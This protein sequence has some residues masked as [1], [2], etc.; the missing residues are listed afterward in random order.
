MPLEIKESRLEPDIT[1]L[2]LAGRLELGGDSQRLEELVAW[3]VGDGRLGVL[4]D[5]TQLEYI[6]STGVGALAMIGGQVKH[7]GGRLV[8]AVREGR[9]K[10]VL[11][12]AR[13]NEIITLAETVEQA[14]RLISGGP[15]APETA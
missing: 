14:A 11:Q 13:L 1:V 5:L 12:F 2:H 8:L 9:V 6:D 15:K 4:L 10:T 3:L 7:S